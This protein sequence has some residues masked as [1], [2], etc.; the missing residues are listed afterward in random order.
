MVELGR[1]NIDYLNL[2]WSVLSVGHHYEQHHHLPRA[3]HQLGGAE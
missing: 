2:A 1:V 3:G